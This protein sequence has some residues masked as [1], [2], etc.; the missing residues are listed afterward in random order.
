MMRPWHLQ[1][2]SNAYNAAEQCKQSSRYSHCARVRMFLHV[3]VCCPRTVNINLAVRSGAKRNTCQ[4]LR[5]AY[6]IAIIACASG[7]LQNDM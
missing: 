2:P 3:T 4:T 6:R 1:N 7:L 5:K